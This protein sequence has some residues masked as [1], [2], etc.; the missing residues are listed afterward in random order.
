MAFRLST[1][2]GLVHY[3]AI[4]YNVLGRKNGVVRRLVFARG[5]WALWGGSTPVRVLSALCG[6]LCC[7]SEAGV[8][9]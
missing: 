8:L 7:G 6:C 9:Y 1:R 3:G 5:Q 4:V 2:T